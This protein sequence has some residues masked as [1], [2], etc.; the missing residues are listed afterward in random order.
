MTRKNAKLILAVIAALLAAGILLCFFVP[1]IN[2]MVDLKARSALLSLKQTL[3]GISGLRL[4]YDDLRFSDLKVITIRNLELFPDQASTGTTRPIVSA[5]EVKLDINLWSALFGQSSDI[6]RRLSVD[7]LVA[8]ISLTEDKAS[9]DRILGYFSSSKGSGGFPSLAIELTRASILVC[10][11]NSA[12][13]S[14]AFGELQVSLASK[15]ANIV[16]PEAFFIASFANA[17][18]SNI[19][20]KLGFLNARVSSDLG[21]ADFSASIGGSADGISLERQRLKGRLRERVVEVEVV[22]GKGIQAAVKY[23]LGGTVVEGEVVLGG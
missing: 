6:L 23:G 21:S 10:D 7:G 19:S 15:F 3:N 12:S 13:Y 16:L 17:K 22:G 4:E 1:G 14:L 8:R 11:A 20:A 2:G 9:I 5:D 18:P